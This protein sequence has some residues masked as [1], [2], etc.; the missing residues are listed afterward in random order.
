M[1]LQSF[2]P[3]GETRREFV[4]QMGQGFTG[5]ALADLLSGDGFFERHASAAD[6]SNSGAALNPL[7]AKKPHFK[8]RAKA[9]IFLTMNG[10]PSQVDTFDYKPELEKFAGKQLPADKNY[11]N[12]G[13]RKVGYLTPAW[14]K[15]KPGGES[16]LL[17]SDYFPM[18]AS[19]PTSCAC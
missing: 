15:F 2:F 16:G 19:T 8:P 3:C 5:L 12:S 4:W 13:G 14:R 1:N 11:I 18:S 6:E 10:A 7:A 17:V 9:C